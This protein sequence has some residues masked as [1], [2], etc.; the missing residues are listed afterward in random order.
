M[1][2]PNRLIMKQLSRAVMLA[3]ISIL[4]FFQNCSSVGNGVGFTQTPVAASCQSV[5]ETT[6]RL[7]K[8]LLMIDSSASTA[9]TDYHREMRLS[10][11]QEF[12]NAYSTKTNFKWGLLAF[13][14]TASMLTSPAFAPYSGTASAITAFNATF[15]LNDTDLASAIALAKNT[16]ASDPDLG[17]AQ[18]PQ[19]VVL[20]MTDGMPDLETN[21]DLVAAATQ[22]RALAPNQITF[23]TLYFGPAENTTPI[24][25]LQN[26]AAAGNGYFLNTN[27]NPN[28]RSFTID[29][30]VN[31]PGASCQ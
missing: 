1:R 10:S 31:I 18:S 5:I 14:D 29:S 16:I 23:N 27:A 25:L 24:A 13:S 15:D 7:T 12:F 22:V 11:M 26:M 6:N 2:K 20:L 28:G 17:S 21:V 9:T 4:A 30:V 8:F 19:Y 3:T